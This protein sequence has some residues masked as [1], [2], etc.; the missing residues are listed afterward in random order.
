MNTHSLKCGGTTRNRSFALIGGLAGTLFLMGCSSGPAVLVGDHD[1]AKTIVSTALD[2]WKAGEKPDKLRSE[3]PKIIVADEDWQSGSALKAYQ[4]TGT[5]LEAGGHWRVS[6]LLTLSANG[7][8]ETQK[9]VAY[10]VTM[11]PEITILR[12][13]DVSE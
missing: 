12:A 9:N 8:S 4:V 2:A 7:K 13:D 10:A 5:P 1:E 6:A 3:T 11:E